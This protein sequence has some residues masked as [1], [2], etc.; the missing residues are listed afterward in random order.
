MLVP[1]ISSVS[2]RAAPSADMRLCDEA[3]RAA[4]LAEY[5]LD[6]LEDDPELARIVQ[7]A[8]SLCNAPVSLVSL[9]EEE[10]QRFLAKVGIAER[11]TPRSTSFCAHAMLEDAPMIVPDAGADPRFADN[12]LVT[13]PP[14][15][16]FYAGAPLV[17]QEGAPL[18]SLCVIDDKP[19]AEGLT[20]LQS[21][22]LN[23]LATAVMRRLRFRRFALTEEAESSIRADRMRTVGDWL[24]NIIW[25]ADA[26][27]AFDYYNARWKALTGEEPPKDAEGWR[28]YI[29]E[30]DQARSFAKWD[31]AVAAGEPFEDEYR[32]RMADGGWRWTLARALPLKDRAGEVQRW[33]GT[34]TD[35]DVSHRRMI[36][37]ELISRE[38]SH[39]IKNI[40]AVINGLIAI[41]SRE[42]PGSEGF[43]KS[44][45]ET[46][47]ALSR[48]HRYV[49]AEG[50]KQDETLLGLLEALLKPYSATSE[51]RVTIDGFDMP[52]GQRSATPL[53]LVFHELATNSAKYGALSVAGG[54]VVVNCAEADGQL[55]ITW[56]EHD[57]PRVAEPENTGFGSR[58]VELTVSSQLK[59]EL[60][61]QFPSD[62]MIATLTVPRDTF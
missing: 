50:E 1:G 61:R 52:L 31:H 37:R 27:G 17:S 54:R 5:G 36:G 40:F 57:G 49:T 8:A 32:F 7:F 13:G 34:L 24:P 11:E 51:H 47:M 59:G 28:P 53:A 3:T 2:K 12:P 20:P 58:L 9:V 6:A 18:G 41:K 56:Q 29:H 44:L 62:G 21:E 45:S 10:R 60:T 30:E 38:L 16:R 42:S 23:V 39:R 14:H 4:V 22:G 35:V 46:L 33:Y 15:I 48:A 43:A 25:S 26:H 19:R 55:V